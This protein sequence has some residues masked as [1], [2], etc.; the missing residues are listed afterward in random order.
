MET[1]RRISKPG[2]TDEQRG[3]LEKTFD[4]IRRGIKKGDLD[5]SKVKR[6]LGKIRCET[7]TVIAFPRAFVDVRI[8]PFGDM[9]QHIEVLKACAEEFG[10]DIF[11]SEKPDDRDA[12]D[13]LVSGNLGVIGQEKLLRTIALTPEELECPRRGSS[14]SVFATELVKCAKGYGLHMLT[15]AEAPQA[16]LGTILQSTQKVRAVG[17]E[18]LMPIT[19]TST[20]K[21]RTFTI[22]EPGERSLNFKLSTTSEPRVHVIDDGDLVLFKQ[23]EH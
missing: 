1:Q 7:G 4:F 13:L 19:K 21:E 12:F 15:A 3:S 9:T 22:Y 23:A 6:E 2:L 11:I 20:G 5:F 14:S 18:A 17:I 10:G 8:R 16:L